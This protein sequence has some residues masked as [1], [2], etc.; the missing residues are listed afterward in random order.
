MIK[1][2]SLA[3]FAAQKAFFVGV[4]V[5]VFG[6]V[7]DLLFIRGVDSFFAQWIINTM[8]GA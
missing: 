2:K 8:A 3:T 1:I 6:I 5:V 4:P 7:A